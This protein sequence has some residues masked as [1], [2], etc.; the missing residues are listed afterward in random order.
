MT[1]SRGT[2]VRIKKGAEIWSTHPNPK[3]RHYFAP[4]AY[5]VKVFDY[6]PERTWKDWEE[7][8]HKTEA[9]IHWAGTGGY[10]HRVKASDVD[11]IEDELRLAMTCCGGNDEHP[12]EHCQDCPDKKGG[13]K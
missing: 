5:K 13:T 3:R 9:T 2:V 4:R 7:V 1:I 8:E 11:N 6:D 10:W 12:P